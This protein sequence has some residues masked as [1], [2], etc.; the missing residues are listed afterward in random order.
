MNMTQPLKSA[1]ILKNESFYNSIDW[2]GLYLQVCIPSLLG[3]IFRFT[4]LQF[5]VYWKNEFVKLSPLVM[6]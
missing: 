6:I 3:K 1:I 5:L 4:V 2:S